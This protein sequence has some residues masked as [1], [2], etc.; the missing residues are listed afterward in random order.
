MK[1]LFALMVA[2]LL[3]FGCCGAVLADAANLN[4]LG[5]LP[6]CK[7]RETLSIL[8][9]EQTLV[10]DYET[11]AFT[12]YLEDTLNIDIEFHFLPGTAAA[13][14]DKLAV[15]VSS[16]EKLPDVVCF[17]LNATNSYK[18]AQSGAFIPMDDLLEDN[19][20]NFLATVAEYPELNLSQIM[21]SPD[22]HQY[23]LP[24][25]APS[26]SDETRYKLW[27]NQKWLD[28]L[29]L[30]MPTTTEEFAEVMRAFKTMDPNGNGKPDE[31]GLVGATGWSQ[32]ATVNLLN[33]FVFNDN[34]NRFIV[35]DGKLDLA[36][37]QDGWK[38]GLLYIKSLIDED[39]FAPISLTQTS[40]QLK[41]MVNNEGD[42]I[43]GCFAYSAH[44]FVGANSPW[45][46]D[47]R[48]VPPLKGPE[49][50]QYAGYVKTVPQFYWQITAD[51]NNPELAMR[52]G[53][54]L[55]DEEIMML[56]RYGIEGEQWTRATAE[57]TAA[58]GAKI[59]FYQTAEQNVFGVAQN[60]NWRGAG[61]HFFGSPMATNLA[62]ASDRYNEAVALYMAHIPAE[63][64]YVPYLM[65]SDGEIEEAAEIRAS[66]KAYVDN[67]T[68]MFI[69]GG[70]DIESGWEGY[71][72]EIKAIGAGNYLAIA[73]Q[74]YDR[75]NSK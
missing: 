47:Y 19:A 51:C 9:M 15:M 66:L 53:D 45:F 34:D 44:T 11:N 26:L 63:G 22:G 36:F 38:Q 56:N 7:E 32:D 67:M 72:D 5:T 29:N 73:Q 28:A 75:E 3:A 74:A 20:P 17:A 49:G 35:K 8:L 61:P 14:G 30:E 68:A 46:E 50:V 58:T 43:V 42:C 2:C 27:I 54:Y 57:E 1:R 4:P 40:E 16:G 65:F 69:T 23:S 60:V 52:V 18:Y 37:T 31:Y 64:E 10:E 48:A 41:A 6:F 71:L 62:S 24:F 70:V 21:R 59:A 12:K 39:L 55:F 25:Y 13:A 33:A